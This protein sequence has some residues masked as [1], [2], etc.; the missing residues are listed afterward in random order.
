MTGTSVSVTGAVTGAS[1]VGGVITG[2]S[3]SVTGT[4][5]AASVVGGVITGTS[6]SVTGTTTAAS[7]VGG[8][9]TGTSV[10]VTGAI[11]G[12]A[13]T[14]TS[15][16]VSTG[17]ITG[18]NLIL[19]GVITD[20]TELTI[21]TTAA[22]G[23]I[24]LTPN[25]TGNV[26]TG[27]NISVTGRVTAASVT[28]G[29]ITGTS[30]SVTGTTT[31]ASVVGGVMTGT[32]VS[33]TGAVTGASVVGGVITGTSTSVTGTT[34]A[35]SVVGG[36]ITGTSTSV[37]GTTTA[38][39]VVG[40][41]MT[42]SSTSVTGNVT[43]A[44][45]VVA[46]N[47]YDASTMTIITG[48][49]DI[50]L[51]PAGNVV[52]NNKNINNLAQ[53]VQ[54][55]DA[56]TKL[57]V[58]NAVSTAISYHQPVT[59]AT[60]TT[61]ATT[62][63]GTITYSQPNGVANGVGAK[64]TTTGS[65]N[66][67][68]TANVQTVGIRI[69]VKNEGN[70]VFNGVYTW[71]N[72]TNIV[73]ATDSD[74]YGA[75]NTSALGINDYF[76][77]S[78]G[79]VNLGSAYIVSAPTGTITFGTSNI[80]F[81]QFSQS[82][83]Y[84]A[85]ASAGISLAGTVI[86][87]K[88]DGVTTAFDGN[89]NISVKPSAALTTPNIGAAT[90][91]SLSVTGAVTAASVVGGVI[92]GTSTSVTGTT[93]AASVVGGVMTG[94]S[95]SVTGAVT[96][97]ST[98]GG[99]I[100]GSSTSVTGNINGGNLNTAGTTTTA[101]AVFD[102]WNLG[103]VNI[104]TVGG[105]TTASGKTLLG[106][107]R[108]AGG[109]EF[110]IIVNR[111]G[112]GTGGVKF[113][114]WANTQTNTTTEIFSVTGTGAVTTPS[115]ISATGAITGAALT[116]TSLTVSTGN[117]T[118]G[119][120]LLSGAITDTG[121]L[122]IQTSASNANIVLTPNGTGNVN[123]GAN[124]SVTGR[125]TAASVVGGVITG[126][127]TSVTGTTTAASVV[128]GV[129]TGS[130]TSVTGT[131]TAA[132]VVGG[133][134]TGSST[135]VTGTTTAASVVGGVMTGSSVSVTGAVTGASLVG[136]LT[137]AAQTNIT[138]VGT[139]TSLSVSGN[140]QGG[141]LRTAGLISATGSI[142]GASVVGGVMTGSSV[143]VTGAVTG[144]STVGGII[145][146]TSTS[147]TGTTTA[148][149]VVGGVITGTSTSVTGTTTA[150]SVVG[151]VMTGSSVSVTGAVTGASLVGTLTTAAQTNIT[152]VGT[153]SSLSVSGNVQAGNISTSTAVI[154]A[155]TTSAALRITQIGTG[156]ALLVEDSANPDS[157]P[158]V[159]NTNGVVIQDKTTARTNYF[160][161]T[162]TAQFQGSTFAAVDRGGAFDAGPA[163]ILSK[164][165]GATGDNTIV[166]SSDTLGQISF[167]GADG[168]NLI[169]GAQIQAQVDGTPGLNDMPGRLMFAT[170]ADGAS[171][172]TERMRIGSTGVITLGAA[173]GAESLRVVPTASAVN[174]L[175]AAG[176]AT[177]ASPQ[178]YAAGSDTNVGINLST[179]GTGSYGLFTNTFAQQQFS[180]AHTASAVNYLQVAGGAT[181]GGPSLLSQGSD[182]NVDMLLKTK[183]TGSINFYT[184]SGTL[185]FLVSHTASAV[186]FLYAT[187]GATGG[188]PTFAVSGSDTNINLT[189][190][191]KGSGNVNT[192]ANVSVTGRV[193]AASIVGGV[194]TGSSTSVTG[195]TT[196]ASV[197]GGVMTG[198]S[199]SV[200]GNVNG[201]NL[202]TA[203]IVSAT[204]NIT[205]PF[206][207]GNGSA[208]T[209]ITASGGSSITNGTSNVVVAASGNVTVGVA[210]TAAVTTFAT[211]GIFVPGLASVTGNVQ[212]G[213]LRTAGLISATGAITGASVVGGVITGTST[214]VTGTT[215]AASVVG[216]V[217]TGSSVSVTGAVTGA[218]LVGTITTAAQTNITSVG[219][220]S[221]LSVTGNVQGGNLR[222]AG[223]ISATGNVNGGNL[224]L[225]SSSATSRIYL[226]SGASTSSLYWDGS[227]LQITGSGYTYFSQSGA[228]Y[229]ASI[230]YARGGISNDT[231]A[232]LTVAGGTSGITYFSGNVGI[233]T[234]APGY[235]LQ[236]VGSFAATTK[237]F[238]IDHPTRP[239]MKLR[240]GSLEGPENGVYVRGRLTGSNTIA[241]PEYWTKLV[242]PNS[243]TVQLTPIGQSQNLY[244]KDIAD[245][246]VTVGGDNINC[247]Y[248]VYAERCDV[249]KLVV[250]I[251]NDND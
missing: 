33:V 6:T 90:G 19:S 37:T 186:N 67:V 73:R 212:G 138:S 173:P 106:W 242:D 171:S 158:F 131:T 83:S 28:G 211:T 182:T 214:S 151:G 99:V 92:T 156:D 157:T 150:A 2:T 153:L 100:T 75:G 126:S 104:A 65:F 4:T 229:S 120:L 215:T 207:I 130:S 198:T 249:D 143:S 221:S 159:I 8:V 76:F 15:L 213:N 191:P 188:S 228:T 96:G 63:G 193:T 71:A 147:V 145:T 24:T 93:T 172:P 17:N 183:G 61:L 105:G 23:N 155:N 160:A 119:N 74:T 185:Q 196:A 202:I 87:A 237:S 149:S 52:V 175:T 10:S 47:I 50:Q 86:N 227:G 246:C 80:A 137:T 84:T 205:A 68:D 101:G 107:N 218:S 22:N 231:G 21:Q 226:N 164:N 13:L 117:I 29:V 209:G 3:T 199:T 81:A 132:S 168:A 247:F 60:T 51:Q 69:L 114:E 236:V 113:Y 82:Q 88:V 112:G 41:V 239:D 144:A 224:V 233:G 169:P 141:N 148:A 127:S 244:V 152:S 129:I 44:N 208:L 108:S 187:G 210:G 195:T 154:S 40:G 89:G 43:G 91:T 111:D 243:I 59:A 125:V 42:G 110:N 139:L 142:T 204:G 216:G 122:D 170:T 167:Q 163:F 1:V 248:T 5:T 238:L 98:V 194:I 85:N 31:A 250:E 94:S 32:S 57:Y 45:L 26:N 235:N 174:Y 30:T 115:T 136:T 161:G 179:K 146:G 103:S 190:T 222:T 245:N 165:R 217:M 95:V 135:S 197:V 232:F 123:T 36:V 180:V 9:M 38:A 25:G 166:V 189:L 70:A 77:V 203:G 176:Q 64:L 7:V 27:A 140:V 128:G 206:F 251:E 220:L 62:T 234:N 39:S 46:T 118:G 66:L 56:A 97:A 79:N 78:S 49:G 18:G 121:Q 102:P 48:A 54:S 184:N 240:Y 35:A 162:S 178:I 124:V 53:P 72:T 134:I 223:L 16:T 192:G 34:T 14:G 241:L 55:Q 116:G 58:D 133:V 201:G 12:A 177:G 230:I 219:T 225:S 20:T 181:T 109:G 200:T 11:N